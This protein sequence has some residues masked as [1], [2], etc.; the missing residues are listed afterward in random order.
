M[1]IDASRPASVRAAVF[2]LWLSAGLALILT[3]AQVT[4]LVATAEAGSTAAIGMVTTGLLALIAAKLGAGRGWA[5]WLFAAIYIAGSLASA[6]LALIAPELFRAL[7]A[8]LQGST[9]VQFVLQTTALVLVF[10]GASR[11]WFKS[12]QLTAP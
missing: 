5:R 3:L 10:T 12:R 11:R 8:L 7:P 2:C 9:L 1:A 4:G 6:A